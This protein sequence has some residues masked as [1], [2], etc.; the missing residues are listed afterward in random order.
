MSRMTRTRMKWARKAD[1]EI[2]VLD[3]SRWY[4]RACSVSIKVTVFFAL[5][6]RPLVLPTSRGT[7]RMTERC[8]KESRVLESGLKEKKKCIHVGMRWQPRVGRHL[9]RQKLLALGS[10]Y[11]IASD[12]M[13]TCGTRFNLR[14][15]DARFVAASWRQDLRGR[16]AATTSAVLLRGCEKY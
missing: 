16:G 12:L 8:K 15:Y 4:C 13:K 14:M 5:R 10:H 3:T 2:A 7:R 1:N 6:M 9:S 11:L